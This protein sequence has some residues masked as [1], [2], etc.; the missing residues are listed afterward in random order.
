MIMITSRP[1]LS[2]AHLQPW[3]RRPPGKLSSVFGLYAVI[4][5][6]MQVN[7]SVVVDFI[8]FLNQPFSINTYRIPNL[9]LSI[10][11]LWLEMSGDYWITNDFRSIS[12]IR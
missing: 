7:S 8:T 4:V 3:F 11:H 5:N 9:T 12:H 2:M 6:I 10:Q 1:H